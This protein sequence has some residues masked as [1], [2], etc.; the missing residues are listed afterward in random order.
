MKALKRPSKDTIIV[1]LGGL[2]S[3]VDHSSLFIRVMSEWQGSSIAW[4]TGAYMK[5]T[6]SADFLNKAT[7]CNKDFICQSPDWV[8][9]G[10]VTEMIGNAILILEEGQYGKNSCPYHVAYGARDYCTCP[11]RVEI[12]HRYRM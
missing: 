5:T 12:Y 8:P 3:V 11:A 10:S 7:R 6:I 1:S 9:C 2:F 4:G